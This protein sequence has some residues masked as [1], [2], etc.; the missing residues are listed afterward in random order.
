MSYHGAPTIADGETALLDEAGIIPT[1]AAAEGSIGE[2]LLATP[3]RFAGYT[4]PGLDSPFLTDD[5]GTTYYR[6]GALVIGS[7]KPPLP[8]A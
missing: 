2:L 3:Q 8:R 6:T 1:S 4:D 5:R 7:R